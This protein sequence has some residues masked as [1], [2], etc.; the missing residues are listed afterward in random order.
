MIEIM[1]VLFC[2]PIILYGVLL[3][4]ILDLPYA[5]V[6]EAEELP[7][8]TVVIPFRNEAKNLKTLIASLTKLRYSA[9]GCNFIF[10]NDHSDDR[11]AEILNELLMDFPFSAQIIALQ[12]DDRGKKHALKKGVEAAQSDWIL[13]TDADCMHHPDWLMSYA[14]YLQVDHYQMVCGPLI[15][16]A[17]RRGWLEKLQ[18]IEQAILTLVG[19][20]T[21]LR[22]QGILANGANMAFRRTAFLNADL[23]A[24]QSASGDD[25]FLLHAVK[26]KDPSC[27]AFN[28]QEEAKVSTSGIDN[29]KAFFAQRLRW[30]SKSKYYQ[31]PD[32]LKFG[33]VIFLTNLSIILA[34]IASLIWGIYW[35]YFFLLFGLKMI[36]DGMIMN[37]AIRYLDG[38][39]NIL[40]FLFFSIL[41]PIYSIGIALLSLLFKPRWKGR[42]I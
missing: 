39:I 37:K 22:K 15:L 25:I 24:D 4:P 29:W 34:F 26:E 1:L 41:Y 18:R 11:G 2:L 7:K 21:I 42:N 8:L 16:K 3:L 32:S 27:I 28:S 33:W 17:K 19:R 14:K 13:I 9:Q 31:D 6:E 36:I 5:H 12:K 30:A 38:K 10:V 23:K 20:Q 35:P 40:D